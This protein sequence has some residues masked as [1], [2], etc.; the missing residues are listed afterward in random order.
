ME[1]ERH[2]PDD[3]TEHQSKELQPLR[4]D[5]TVV[6]FCADY[7]ASVSLIRAHASPG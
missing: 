3:F 6:G 1:D 2:L 5:C 7:S 4:V